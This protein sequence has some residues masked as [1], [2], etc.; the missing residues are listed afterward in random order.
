MSANPSSAV[1]SERRREQMRAYHAVHRDE[2]LAK[3]R[4]YREAR[5]E[6][7]SEKQ[8][9]YAQKNAEAVRARDRVRNAARLMDPGYRVKT[10]ERQRR[11]NRANGDV[12]AAWD[13][14]HREHIAARAANRRARRA[15]APGSFTGDEFVALCAAHS[16]RCAYCGS[17]AP[18]TPDHDVPLSRGGSNDISN[19]VPA[20]LSCN[21]RKGGATAAEYR[22]KREAA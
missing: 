8:R 11:W 17:D 18:L 7:L 10:L 20:C 16:H 22:A 4:A 12:K 9:V 13:A 21:A 6:E 3:K 1:T 14:A 15:G 2:I 5:R 19:I